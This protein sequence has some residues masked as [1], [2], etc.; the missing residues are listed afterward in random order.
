VKNELNP[1]APVDVLIRLSPRL[2]FTLAVD[3]VPIGS[4]PGQ[5]VRL[6]DAARLIPAINAKIQMVFVTVVRHT[7]LK[8]SSNNTVTYTDAL[9]KQIPAPTNAEM[10]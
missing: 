9:T 2:M 1:P 5:L 10:I 4:C 7:S 6:A 3:V 8:F